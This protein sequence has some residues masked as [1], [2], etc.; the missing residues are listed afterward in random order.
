M[1]RTTKIVRG[2]LHAGFVCLFILGA[3][4]IPRIATAQ[5]TGT[6]TPTGSMTIP[7]TGH[8]ATLLANG[9]VLIAGGNGPLASAELYDP[10]TGTFTPTGAMT[11]A[12][13]LGAATL[14]ADGRVLLT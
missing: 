4:G 12:G 9:K 5:S 8:T 11:M 14:M 2:F 6:F 7:R 1:Q 13:N 3:S 10:S